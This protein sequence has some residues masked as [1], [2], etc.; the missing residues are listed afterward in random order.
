M[1][2]AFAL[3][4]ALTGAARA[5]VAADYASAVTTFGNP[6]VYGTE[7]ELVE[8]KAYLDGLEGTWAL[9]SGADGGDG[10]FNSADFP[11]ICEKMGNRLVRTGDY[12]FDLLRTTPD[13]E[14]AFQ[15]RYAGSG[16]FVR[17]VSESDYFKWLGFEG[18]RKQSMPALLSLSTLS[19]TVRLFVVSPDLIVMM[20]E[21]GRQEYWARCP[22]E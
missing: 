3:I 2:L 4:L 6:T 15:H 1:R 10:A 12:S 21:R 20:P 5:D 11:T 13:G 7:A 19:V 18:E 14:L 22:V 8:T 17:F 9:M 16:Q